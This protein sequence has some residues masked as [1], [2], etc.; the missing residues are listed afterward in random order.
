MKDSC[1]QQSQWTGYQH[2]FSIRFLSPNSHRRMRRE[3]GDTCI[4]KWVLNRRGAGE[5]GVGSGGSRGC[6]GSECWRCRGRLILEEVRKGRSAELDPLKWRDGG[7]MAWRTSNGFWSWAEKGNRP[8]R[9]PVFSKNGLDSISSSIC[10][11]RN[12][13]VPHPEVESIFPPLGPL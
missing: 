4:C 8:V 10:F 9:Q 12:S 1:F 7:E 13:P 6:R 11:S 5:V 3:P 2:F